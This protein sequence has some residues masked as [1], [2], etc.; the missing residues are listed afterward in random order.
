V[1]IPVRDVN[2]V[3]RTPWVTYMLIAVNFVVFLLTP[4]LAITVTGA[5]NLAQTCEQRAFFDH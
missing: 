4:A 5:D 1:V 3:Q 2:P